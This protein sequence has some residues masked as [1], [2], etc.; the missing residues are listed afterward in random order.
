VAPGAGAGCIAEGRALAE[1][2]AERGEGRLVPSRDQE[3]SLVSA[4]KGTTF[5]GD[6]RQEPDQQRPDG[7]CHG[8]RGRQVVEDGTSG[9]S[10][11]DWSR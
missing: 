10:G 4:G 2:V 11:C 9:E 6:E 1:R 3:I 5:G 7:G 8:R